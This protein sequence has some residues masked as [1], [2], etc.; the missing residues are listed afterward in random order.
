MH[1][2]YVNLLTKWVAGC[3]GS[4]HTPIC[5]IQTTFIQYANSGFGCPSTAD[6]PPCAVSF[7]IV[8]TNS[9]TTRVMQ[10]FEARS[11]I[12]AFNA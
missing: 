6:M 12:R 8:D 10:S 2:A 9:F 1:P 11:Q 5:G 7:V 3:G 4:D